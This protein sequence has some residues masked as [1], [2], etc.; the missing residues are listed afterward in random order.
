MQKQKK[1][2]VSPSLNL[3]PIF[4]NQATASAHARPAVPP[5]HSSQGAPKAWRKLQRRHLS[6]AYHAGSVGIYHRNCHGF[7]GIGNGGTWGCFLLNSANIYKKSP[8]NLG[9]LN[10]VRC[11]SPWQ[12]SQTNINLISPP[13][14]WAHIRD[15]SSF[16]SLNH[17]L[18]VVGLVGSFGEK[19]SSQLV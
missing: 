3:Q 12:R 17:K 1:L 14:N 2:Q 11:H 10:F 15:P 13:Q 7:L 4:S 9:E 16:R 19:K 8:K 18:A 6:D 5:S